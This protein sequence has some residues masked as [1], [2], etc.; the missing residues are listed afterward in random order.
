MPRS[1][2]AAEVA[3]ALGVRRAWLMDG[4]EPMRS[5]SLQVTEGQPG[6]YGAGIKNRPDEEPAAISLSPAEFLLVNRYRCLPRELQAS[7]D[8]MLQTLAETLPENNN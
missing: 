7:F 2:R 8:S 4:E 1:T 3:T 6:P 5:I